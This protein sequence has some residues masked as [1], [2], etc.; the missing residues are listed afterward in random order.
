MGVDDWGRSK[1]GIYYIILLLYCSLTLRCYDGLTFRRSVLVYFY[2][3]T[4]FCILCEDAVL[5]IFLSWFVMDEAVGFF[6]L[7]NFFSWFLLM[8]LLGLYADVIY[9]L[10][11]VGMCK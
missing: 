8:I 1:V 5:F 9:Y 3:E 2:V 7:G 10:F 4:C 6:A 11:S